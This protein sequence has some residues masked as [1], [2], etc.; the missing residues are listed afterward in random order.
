LSHAG[1][2]Q[3]AALLLAHVR[4]ET[5]QVSPE[6]IDADRHR[7]RIDDGGEEHDGGIAVE[8]IAHAEISVDAAGQCEHA[9]RDAR[10]DF[11]T[12]NP[13]AQS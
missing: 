11:E 6:G 13:V 8:Q 9:E 5:H 3:R 7:H 4:Q 12:G 1:K 10:G 2:Q